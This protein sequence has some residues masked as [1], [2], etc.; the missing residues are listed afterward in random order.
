VINENGV[1]VSD[2]IH[3]WANPQ[4]A[5]ALMPSI[6]TRAK[7]KCNEVLFWQALD[8]KSNRTTSSAERV[9]AQ[10]SCKLTL[11]Q[12]CASAHG[13]AAVLSSGKDI[14]VLCQW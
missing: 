8:K 3:P 13:G 1:K 2:K 11:E 6:Q 10:E 7:E 9:Q 12:I 4:E 14:S 5:I